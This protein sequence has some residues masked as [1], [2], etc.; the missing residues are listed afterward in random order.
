[1]QMLDPQSSWVR[2]LVLPLRLVPL[3]PLVSLGLR[4]RLNREIAAALAISTRSVETHR[5]KNMLKLDLHFSQRARSVRR[6]NNFI[7]S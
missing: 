3:K 6:R 1:L 2:A 4:G 5:A 7:R